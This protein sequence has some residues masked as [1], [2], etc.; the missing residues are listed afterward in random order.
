MSRRWRTLAQDISRKK[1]DVVKLTGGAEGRVMVD[2][3]ATVGRWRATPS[4]VV[5][6][7]AA[8]GEVYM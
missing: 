6:V 2:F 5:T 4:L 3:V 7:A 8:A 1:V